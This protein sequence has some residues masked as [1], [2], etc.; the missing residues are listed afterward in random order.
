MVA[1][2]LNCCVLTS[3]DW[4]I[5]I[6]QCCSVQLCVLEAR[7]ARQLCQCRDLLLV[8]DLDQL[9]INQMADSKITRRLA[10]ASGNRLQASRDF[11]NLQGL[12]SHHKMLACRWGGWFLLAP[13]SAPASA[14]NIGALGWPSQEPE[15][16]ARARD[17][18]ALSVASS[19]Y[20]GRRKGSPD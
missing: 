14:G 3:C 16:K 2:P 1:S 10:V 6:S 18:T 9:L 11:C 15:P 17:A 12:T 4:T 5:S 8:C 19:S 7:H 20:L 13:A